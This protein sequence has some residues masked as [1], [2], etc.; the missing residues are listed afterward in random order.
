MGN[1]NTRKVSNV[2]EPIDLMSLIS[3]AVISMYPKK[4][5]A[6]MHRN[7]RFRILKGLVNVTLSD[8]VIELNKIGVLAQTHMSNIRIT[9][10][11]IM[12][13]Y[14]DSDEEDRTAINFACDFFRDKTTP[15][16]KDLLE[17][18]TII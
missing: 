10:K 2:N 16:Y 11:F 17:R 13:L 9:E 15:E 18:L 8:I 7:K 4:F 14:E 3:G 1:V 5:G 6:D 12:E